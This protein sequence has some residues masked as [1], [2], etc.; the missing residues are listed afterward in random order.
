VEQQEPS[1][2]AAEE[3]LRRL[4]QRLDRAS[5]AAERVI[6]EAAAAASEPPPAGWQV[7]RSEERRDDLDLLLQLVN[8]LRDLVPPELQRRLAE[9]LRELLLALRALIDWYLER[10]ERR[11][12]APADVEDIPIT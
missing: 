10:N 7:P 5:E 12:P 11:R 6:A 2:S 1:P 9:T 8:S 3:A 4:E